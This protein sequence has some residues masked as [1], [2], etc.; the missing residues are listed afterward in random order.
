M[1]VYQTILLLFQSYY[2][3]LY[4]NIILTNQYLSHYVNRDNILSFYIEYHS[5]ILDLTVNTT[6]EV[7]ELVKTLKEF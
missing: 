4:L 6:G 7:E 1:N 5:R 2:N 3:Q